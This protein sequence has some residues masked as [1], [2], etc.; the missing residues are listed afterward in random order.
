MIRVYFFFLRRPA[1]SIKNAL[2]LVAQVGGE[3]VPGDY[4]STSAA[5]LQ[6]VESQKNALLARIEAAQFSDQKNKRK[7]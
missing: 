5:E 7:T 1:N 4:E 3:H 2:E 6:P